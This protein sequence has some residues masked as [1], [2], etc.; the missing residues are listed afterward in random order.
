MNQW[1]KDEEKE[2]GNDKVYADTRIYNNNNAHAVYAV[3]FISISN[4]MLKK[5]KDK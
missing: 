3:Q 1:E 5:S 4:Q 2:S